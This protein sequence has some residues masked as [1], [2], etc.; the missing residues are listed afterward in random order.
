MKSVSSLVAGLTLVAA[1]AAPAI[2]QTQGDTQKSQEVK[3]TASTA[4][5]K[6]DA[7]AAATIPAPL[8]SSTKSTAK[9]ARSS[10]SRRTPP[11]PPLLRHSHAVAKKGSGAH[12]TLL[13]PHGR[14]DMAGKQVPFYP[15]ARGGAEAK[16]QQA[17]AYRAGHR[18][19]KKSQ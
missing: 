4:Q 13:D 15:G 8:S 19:A 16:K 1:L 3:A 11:P 10:K 14:T 2:A 7:A 9:L 18:V 5:P 17:S 6:R 12:A